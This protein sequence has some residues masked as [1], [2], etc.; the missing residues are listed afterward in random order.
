MRRSSMLSPPPRR[1]R[2]PLPMLLLVL[3][4]LLVGFLVWLST[5]DTEVPTQRIEQD[6]TNAA[7]AR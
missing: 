5:I 4:V 1:R 6:V 7:L 3:L 2:S